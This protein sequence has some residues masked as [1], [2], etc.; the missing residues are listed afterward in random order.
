MSLTKDNLDV[1]KRVRNSKERLRIADL[2]V[3]MD[4][5][6]LMTHFYEQQDSETLVSRLVERR[7]F[8]YLRSFGE[9]ITTTYGVKQLTKIFN[10]VEFDKYRYGWD[11]Y[12]G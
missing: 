4:S 10:S 3:I 1:Y 12:V 11:K 9:F 2:K 8:H 7:W 5:K 6:S